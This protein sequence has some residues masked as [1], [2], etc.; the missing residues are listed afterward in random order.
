MVNALLSLRALA[1]LI[2]CNCA[3]T[4]EVVA[5]VVK[6]DRSSFLHWIRNGKPAAERGDANS[7]WP[8][9]FSIPISRPMIAAGP[10]KA[11]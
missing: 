3:E 1:S 5:S 9:P 11:R 4:F 2:R 7:A 10:P 8:G 6:H